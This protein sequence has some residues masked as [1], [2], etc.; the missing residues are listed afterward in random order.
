MARVT[1][2]TGELAVFN[3]WTTDSFQWALWQGDWLPDPSTEVFVADLGGTEIA[4]A[5]YARLNMSLPT[6]AV[7]LPATSDDAGFVNYEADDP[8][9]GVVGGGQVAAWLVLYRKITNDADS[10]VV[11]AV[12]IGHTCD[13]ISTAAF[14]LPD[15]VAHGVATACTSAF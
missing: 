12:D 6:V 1:F 3:G 8:S 15:G 11:S 14:T 7:V 13:G 9:F 2:P 10:P 4:G 5:G